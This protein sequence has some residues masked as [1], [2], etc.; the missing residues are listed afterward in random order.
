VPPPGGE[1][2]KDVE[3]RIMPFIKEV[4]RNMKEHKVDVLIVSHSN[5]IRPIRKYFEGLT[6]KQMMEL[7]HLRHKIFK[8]EIEV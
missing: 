2:I 6:N 1:S 3:E 5:A 4:L 8:Y 7:E